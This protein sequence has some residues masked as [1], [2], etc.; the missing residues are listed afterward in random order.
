MT[1]ERVPGVAVIVTCDTCKHS[2]NWS[3]QAAAD[4]FLASSGWIDVPGSLRTR[5]RCPVCA[6]PETMSAFKG[7]YVPI[8]SQATRDSL[9]YAR[10]PR[11]APLS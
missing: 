1:P 6:N 8:R 9:T 11:R 5:K 4:R 7:D 2:V 3:T 10:G